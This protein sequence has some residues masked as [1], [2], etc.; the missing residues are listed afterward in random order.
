MKPKEFGI[1]DFRVC[2]YAEVIRHIPMSNEDVDL[3][4]LDAENPTVRQLK[5]PYLE[6]DLRLKLKFYKFYRC[7]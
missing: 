4:I 3:E 2:W 5:N 1:D 7:E 6:V